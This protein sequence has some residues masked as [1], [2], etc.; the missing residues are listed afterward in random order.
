MFPLL[1]GTDSCTLCAA[2]HLL[3]MS[4]QIFFPF[5]GSTAI[6]QD[7]N[8]KIHLA[9]IV[10]EW[11]K[12]PESAFSQIDCPAQSPDLSPVQS[13]WCVLAETFHRGQEKVRGKTVPE[14]TPKNGRGRKGW[15]GTA[16]ER[17]NSCMLITLS[18]I[19]NSKM[20]MCKVNKLL[21]VDSQ[22]LTVWHI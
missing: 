9:Q 12:E 1:F 19:A 6:F 21:L 11:A 7:D 5:P 17:Y 16:G 22:Y 2:E 10:T 4:H 18:V 15:G 3:L 20:K 14:Q 13:Q 8:A